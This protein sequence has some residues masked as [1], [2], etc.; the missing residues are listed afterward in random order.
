M[1]IVQRSISHSGNIMYSLVWI[2]LNFY[3]GTKED[4]ARPV[5]QFVPTLRV[6]VGLF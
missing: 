6:K 3:H 5:R 2:R 1:H 4:P